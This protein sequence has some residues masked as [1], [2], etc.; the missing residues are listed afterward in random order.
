MKIEECS[1]C[2]TQYSDI[3]RCI[4]KLQHLES[5]P[6]NIHSNEACVLDPFICNI[7]TVQE[8]GNESLSNLMEYLEIEYKLRQ[9]ALTTTGNESWTVFM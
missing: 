2:E 9:K 4:N 3:Y 7:C 1:R 6:C 8:K 5:P